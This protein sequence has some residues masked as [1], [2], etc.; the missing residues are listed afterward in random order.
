MID[1][2]SGKSMFVNT[3]LKYKKNYANH[4]LAQQRYFEN[5]LKNQGLP[6]T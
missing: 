2:E 3:S 6:L 1:Q 4:F 5:I